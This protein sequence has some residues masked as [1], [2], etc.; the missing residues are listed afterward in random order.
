MN[1]D[2]LIIEEYKLYVE[3]ADR[4]S[5]RRVETNK[6]FISIITAI[7]AFITIILQTKLLVEHIHIVLISFSILGIFLCLIWFI[8]IQSYKQLN[9]A[10]FKVIHQLEKHLPFKCFEEEWGLL[11]KG[12]NSKKYKRIT[13]VEKFVPI[14]LCAPLIYLL[15]LGILKWVKS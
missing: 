8:N 3:M 11:G 14:L 7:L 9:S 6:Y 2:D 12:K 5:Q 1:K 10:K 4:I 15:I 13:N